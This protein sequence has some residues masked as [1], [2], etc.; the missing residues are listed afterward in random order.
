MTRRIATAIVGV[1]ALV[2]LALGIPLAIAVHRTILQSEVVELQAAAARSLAEIS[3][4]L[5]AS[6]LQEL[7]V[8]DDD[9]GVSVYDV[10]G[11]RLFGDGPVTPD[12]QTRRALR[13]IPTTT[14]TGQ[15]VV[16]YPIT[17]GTDDNIV[18]ALRLHEDRADMTQ[19]TAIAWAVMAAAA[20][21]ALGI[22]WFIARILA[23][24]LGRPVD[25][26]AGLAVE[27][28][29]GRV[30]DPPVATDIAELDA[31][32]VALADSSRQAHEVLARERRFSADVS[33]QLRTPLT[34]LRLALEQVETDPNDLDAITACMTDLDRIE[35]TVQHLLAYAREATPHGG[36]TDLDDAAREAA[37]RWA[38]AAAAHDRSIRVVAG[39]PDE[40]VAQANRVAVDQTLDVLIDNAIRYGAG[41]IDVEVRSLA[42]GVAIDVSDDGRRALDE[43]VFERGTGHGNG[44]GLALARSITEAEGGRLLLTRRQPP[45]FSVVL[46][47]LTT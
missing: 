2:L 38:D 45:T 6:E 27:I 14:T 37:V 3:V 15:L 29:Q 33:H 26:L 35:T 40:H 24:R 19:R 7:T 11:R 23:R 25:R 16:A 31:L 5:Q 1:T 46:L 17:S 42:G 32:G 41:P 34:H 9:Q 39:Q 44:I 47:E 12:D 43:T 13:G 36:A 18:G 28:G 21:V 30:V 8:P 4:P 22:A 10:N 20:L